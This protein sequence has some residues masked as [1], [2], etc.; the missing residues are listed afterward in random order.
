LEEKEMKRMALSLLIVLVLC[1]AAVGSEDE[2]G[3]LAT[4]LFTDANE[5]ALKGI[6]GKQAHNNFALVA[7]LAI[8]V[9][10]RR[11][12]FT[13]DEVMKLKCLGA[14]LGAWLEMGGR[15]AHADLIPPNVDRCIREGGYDRGLK[16]R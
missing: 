12:F 11:G 16:R 1:G 10:K 13:E 6:I 2:V 14:A 5:M 4:A 15:T 7:G 9:G 3:R 8:E